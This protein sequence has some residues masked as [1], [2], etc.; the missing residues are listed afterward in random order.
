MFDKYNRVDAIGKRP[1]TPYLISV[2]KIQEVDDDPDL[3]YFTDESRYHNVE[4][5]EKRKYIKQ[6]AQRLAAYYN[7][8]WY[9]VGIRIEALIGIPQGPQTIRMLTIS[10]AGCWGIESDSESDYF[11]LVIG[12]ECSDLADILTKFNIVDKEGLPIS[13]Q[14]I[15][16]AINQP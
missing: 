3:S 5:N 11:A 6:D 14:A 7:D 9:Y 8:D 12:E 4:D 13:D 15:Q 10:S 16:D 1:D 2:K